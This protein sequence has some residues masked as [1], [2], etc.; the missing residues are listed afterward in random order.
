VLIGNGGGEYAMRG[1]VSAY[2]VQDGKL[3]WR[4]YTVP[5]DKGAPADGAASDPMIAKMQET[6][7]GDYAKLGGGG[8]VWDTIIFDREFN[9][10]IF[11]VGNGVPWDRAIRSGDTGDNL[12]LSSIVA[13]DADSG[14]YKWHY[15]GS[16][17]ESW[18]YDQTQLIILASLKIEGADRKV[19]MQAPKNGFFYVIDRKDGKL[20]SAKNFAFQ[21]WTTGIDMKTGRPIEAP[22]ARY[23]KAAFL[24]IPSGQ[25]AHNWQPMAFSPQ[26]GLAYIP[27]QEVPMLYE[28]DKSASRSSGSM[29]MTVNMMRS[30]PNSPKSRTQRS[31]APDCSRAHSSGRSRTARNMT[32]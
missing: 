32:S 8:P 17:G 30:A 14:T 26:T 18:D 25:G 11:G 9:H 24:A 7:S 1:Y 28:A 22:G 15:S 29:C 2:D 19:L 23:A 3:V 12:F 27:T 13:V 4:F 5:P 10:V 20:L 6:W 16:P 31:S 21:N